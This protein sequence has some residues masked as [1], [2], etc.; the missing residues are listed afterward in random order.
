[1]YFE[2]WKMLNI[3]DRPYASKEKQS[4]LCF[5]DSFLPMQIL[6]SVSTIS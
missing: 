2:E 6:D 3:D 5:G 1:M 4:Q